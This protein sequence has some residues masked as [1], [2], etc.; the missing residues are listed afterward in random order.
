[1][2]ETR[3]DP[4]TSRC[5]WCNLIRVRGTWLSERRRACEVVY[6]HG[7]CDRCTVGLLREMGQPSSIKWFLSQDSSLPEGMAG[8]S[9][10]LGTWPDDS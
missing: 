3:Q 5:A 7:I 10:F 1:M 9:P 8:G 6:T 2:R 4:M